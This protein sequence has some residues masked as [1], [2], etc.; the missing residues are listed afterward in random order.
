M[1]SKTRYILAALLVAYLIGAAPVIIDF[2]E[3]KIIFSSNNVISLRPEVAY[4]VSETLERVRS[5]SGYFIVIYAAIVAALIFLENSNPDR[6][7]LWIAILVLVPFIGLLVYLLIG[8]DFDN[9]RRRR[10]F[11]PGEFYPVPS[12][13]KEDL[14]VQTAQM[15]N[16]VGTVKLTR[17]NRIKPL[18]N[19]EETFESMFKEMNEAKI[20]IHLQSF[21]I[22]DDEMGR[23]LYD[24]LMSAAQRGVIVRVLY[25]AIGSRK[26][27][28]A[29]VRGL[30]DAGVN[31]MS[32]MPV[33]FPMF[34]R[35]MNFR[36]HRKICVVDG[37]VAFTG[38]LNFNNN[39]I[40]KGKNG[41]WRDTHVR[42]EGEAVQ[43]LHNIFLADWQDRTGETPEAV[44]KTDKVVYEQDFSGL[45][46]LPVQVVPSGV[47]S[48]WHSIEMGFF[49]M[50]TRAK[51]RIWITTPYLVPGPQIMAALRVAALSG[52]DVRIMIPEVGDSFLV[53]W[54][55]RSNLEE[56]LSAGVKIYLYRRGFIHAKTV[57]TDGEICSVGTCNLDVRSLE[58][59]F[60]DQLFIYDT[61]MTE[62]FAR[63][64]EKDME[65]SRRLTLEEWRKRG[66]KERLLE[67]FGKLYSAQI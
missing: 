27:T 61:V 44:I 26:I 10:K 46:N 15:L 8:P 37:K 48:P 6:T 39:Y 1:W 23:R 64:Y 14:R 19:G 29:Y 4:Y 50:I 45:P 18:I 58:I 60:E 13:F 53:Y 43:E 20:F 36:N 63:Q 62:L 51:E 21:I 7:L 32:F 24:V 54:G 22:K 31:C 38:G 40:H 12:K 56:L 52:V 33:S 2:I 9:L 66:F 42:I 5:Y 3:D 28:K 55:G 41:F 25:D 47:S 65:E 59:N 30:Q 57:V 11:R 17:K 49:S 16:E 34:R 67:S 35:R